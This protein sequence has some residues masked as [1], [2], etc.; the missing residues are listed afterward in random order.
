MDSSY[1]ENIIIFKNP[2]FFQHM[3]LISQILLSAPASL[4]TKIFYA[5]EDHTATSKNHSSR[6]LGESY[7]LMS[8]A[9]TISDS[10]TRCYM[11]V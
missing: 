11:W 5:K 10:V 9:D 2:S 7:F 8:K 1:P 4:H 3:K 6:N